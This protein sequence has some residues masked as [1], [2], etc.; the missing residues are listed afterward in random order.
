LTVIVTG[1]IQFEI[2][3]LSRALSRSTGLGTDFRE[4]TEQLRHWIFSDK[5]RRLP[6]RNFC[7]VKGA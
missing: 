5:D 3:A 7:A 2:F 1:N 6:V 4:T